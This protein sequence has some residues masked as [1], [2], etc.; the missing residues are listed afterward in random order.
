MLRITGKNSKTNKMI[1][2]RELRKF[3]FKLEY[4]VNKE[5]GETWVDKIY[6]EREEEG[7]YGILFRNTMNNTSNGVFELSICEFNYIED[8][9]KLIDSGYVTTT[10]R[11]DF[12][13][14]D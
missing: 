7:V 13:K 4:D 3:G 12:N 2:P 11:K 10:G 9:F 8:L 14:E 6:I 5:T 1:E